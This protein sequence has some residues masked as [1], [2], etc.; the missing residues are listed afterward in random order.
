MDTPTQT[1][2]TSLTEPFDDLEAQHVIDTAY[3]VQY[4]NT[5]VVRTREQAHREELFMQ[6]SRSRRMVK[7]LRAQLTKARHRRFKTTRVPTDILDQLLTIVENAD[8]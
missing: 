3:D 1:I 2:A 8:A 6:R 7:L 5:R 4:G